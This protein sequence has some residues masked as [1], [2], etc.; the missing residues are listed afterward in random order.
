MPAAARD[1]RP[2]GEPTLIVARRVSRAG[3][4]RALLWGR[5]APA[6]TW[7]RWPTS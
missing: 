5:G 4:S 1:L 3:R 2:D 7:P 6:P